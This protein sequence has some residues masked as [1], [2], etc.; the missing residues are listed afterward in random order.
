[1]KQDMPV[2]IPFYMERKFSGFFSHELA[3]D[4]KDFSKSSLDCLNYMAHNIQQFRRTD[5]DIYPMKTIITG[6]HTITVEGKKYRI[7]GYVKTTE[8]EYFLEYY[9]CR[10]IFY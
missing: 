6:E 5:D 3:T 9:G 10:F 7:D 1:M 2:G 8:K 4:R